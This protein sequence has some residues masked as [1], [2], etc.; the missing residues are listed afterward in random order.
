MESIIKLLEEAKKEFEDGSHWDCLKKLNKARKEAEIILKRVIPD[1]VQKPYET[2]S[3]I[4]NAIEMGHAQK[5]EIPR[6]EKAIDAA[7]EVKKDEL[8]SLRTA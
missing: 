5:I 1:E 2:I 7:K 4:I 3:L 8:V 6:I